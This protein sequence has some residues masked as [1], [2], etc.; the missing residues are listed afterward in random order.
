MRIQ[1][2]RL[3]FL[4]GWIRGFKAQLILI[5]LPIA[6]LGLMFLLRH[7]GPSYTGDEIA[8]LTKAATLAGKVNAVTDSRYTGYAFLL[9]PFFRM[10]PTVEE[11]WPGVILINTVALI[12]SVLCLWVSLQKCGAANRERA[13]RLVLL[14]ML[15]FGSLSFIN[16]AFPNCLLMAL[17]G[18]VVLLFSLPSFGLA[19]AVAVGLIL[20]YATWVHPTSVAL[21]F[22]AALASTWCGSKRSRWR[23]GA[24]ILVIG[25]MLF[26]TH[27][28]V[29]HPWMNSLQGS[30]QG[31]YK[32]VVTGL[33]SRVSFNSG[34]ALATVALGI[35]NGLATSAIASFGYLG[36]A[37]A[38][39]LPNSHRTGMPPSIGSETRRVMV[40]LLS[41]WGLLLLIS[42][43][44][45]LFN[46]TWLQHA[47]HHRY[48]QPVLM[49]IVVYGMAMAPRSW[50]DRLSVWGFSAIPILLSLLISIVLVDYDERFNIVDQS[51]AITFFLQPGFP[52]HV[53][54][55][56]WTGLL[57]TATVQLLGVRAFLP[58]SAGLSLLGWQRINW[59][60]DVALQ[61]V[62]R[63][64]AMA[65][66][67]DTM[68][69]NGMHTCVVLPRSRT[70]RISDPV[71]QQNRLMRYYLSGLPVTILPMGQQAPEH[72]DVLIQP[73]DLKAS[74]SITN[75]TNN[76]EACQPILA[77]THRN[78]VL[79][80]CRHRSSKPIPDL[81]KLLLPS[82]R[83][84]V[85]LKRVQQLQ[86]N[87]FRI[88]ALLHRDEL[89][90]V[91][92]RD[93]SW[94]RAF[95]ATA[96]RE[97][98]TSGTR[99]LH[100]P[101][102]TLPAG[103][104]V[105]AYDGLSTSSSSIPVEMTVT[106][107]NGTHILARRLIQQGSGSAKLPFTLHQ[108]H[109]AI[110]VILDAK[111]DGQVLMPALLVIFGRLG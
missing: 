30:G 110:E 72:C 74:G 82:R 76:P 84:L 15:V 35:L 94:W 100:G 56:L 98:V 9:A 29:V 80:D 103:R 55:M 49:G 37:L 67:V 64:P 111:E 63:P 14:G 78:Q 51:A 99:L 13:T 81:E 62:A 75:L 102:L 28:R 36:S 106:R 66:A 45:M 108:P 41:S 47:F 43:P 24:V 87:G 85:S 5:I 4:P 50:A 21:L 60:Q 93:A 42:A 39:V 22:S 27:L 2:S 73:L 32:A 52:T 26:L 48:C 33:T 10:V 70:R 31:H 91:R 68:V 61:S 38:A 40:F 12:I 19:H 71:N 107:D 11:V 83:D 17:I 89:P 54:M 25:L 109:R 105:A 20:G 46:P 96:T 92:P 104:Y 3:E 95:P 16:W 69:R 59:M 97:P 65:R 34:V 101:Y 88:M 1:A 6:A 79:L 18:A 77:D 44:L 57:I 53:P 58:L 86:P 23:H 90:P 8:Y 7:G